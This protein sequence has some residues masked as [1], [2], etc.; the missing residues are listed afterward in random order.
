MLI[1]K[2]AI[3]AAIIPLKVPQWIS[4]TRAVTEMS[5]AKSCL[6][7]RSIVLRGSLMSNKLIA[8]N[9]RK[10][11]VIM[12]GSLYTFGRDDSAQAERTSVVAWTTTCG[13]SRAK[14]Q[15]DLRPRQATKAARFVSRSPF[16]ES[17]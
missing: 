5:I 11:D 7:A 1:N 15:S 9:I 10:P 6:S 12:M 13:S 16:G 17:S 14:P 2:P 8:P 3:V 4:S